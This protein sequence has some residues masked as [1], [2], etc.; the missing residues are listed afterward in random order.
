MGC[1]ERYDAMAMAKTKVM[2]APWDAFAMAAR[3]KR[4]VNADVERAI[5]V[6]TVKGLKRNLPG[7]STAVEQTL[8]AH[9][10]QP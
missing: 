10:Q 5:H 4:F 2:L 3:M 9:T 8:I 7:V 1:I 6:A